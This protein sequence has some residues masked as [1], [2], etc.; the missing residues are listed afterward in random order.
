MC[1]RSFRRVTSSAKFDSLSSERRPYSKG[2]L[3]VTRGN[4]AFSTVHAIR[5]YSR[6]LVHD[7]DLLKIGHA[8]RASRTRCHQEIEMLL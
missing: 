8:G 4:W 2:F 7:V 1:R 6:P 5:A 3:L